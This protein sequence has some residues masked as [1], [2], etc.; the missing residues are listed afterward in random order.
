VQCSIVA[1]HNNGICKLCQAVCRKIS[2]PG[3]L[4]AALIKVNQYNDI[5]TTGQ[6]N[7][8]GSI[9]EAQNEPAVAG[10]I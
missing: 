4:R 8:F 10:N 7:Q 3:I 6:G 2:D 9:G 5:E 1:V